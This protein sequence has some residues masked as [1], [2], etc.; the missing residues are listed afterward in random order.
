M[1]P[2][3]HEAMKPQDNPVVTSA[4]GRPL[5][6]P[7]ASLQIRSQYG[8]G[9]LTLLQDTQLIETLAHFPRERIPERV[10]HA[11]AAGAWGEFEVTHDVSDLTDANFL[12]TVG[13]KTPVLARI[14]TVGGEKG[15]ADTVRDVRGWALKLFTEEGNQGKPAP[16]PVMNTLAIF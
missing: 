7:A 9:G 1:A 12:D 16:K 3:N 8:R 11:K 10:V 14:S 2:P 13:K 15:S 5:E 4:E 6:N